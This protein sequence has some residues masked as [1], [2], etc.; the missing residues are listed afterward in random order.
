MRIAEGKESYI[1]LKRNVDLYITNTF[2]DSEGYGVDVLRIDKEENKSVTLGSWNFGHDMKA[3][4]LAERWHKDL[5]DTY[6]QVAK[7]EL[8]EEL[9]ERSLAKIEERDIILAHNHSELLQPTPPSEGKLRNFIHEELQGVLENKGLSLTEDQIRNVIDG[10][11]NW[12][13]NGLYES[14]DAALDSVKS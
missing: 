4:K 10:V 13:Q 6:K 9:A 12:V 7:G 1:C 2:D 5:V 14:I 3:Q 11:E 8:S